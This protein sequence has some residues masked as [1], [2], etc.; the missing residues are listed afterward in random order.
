MESNT[1]CPRLTAWIILSGSAVHVKGFGSAL[2]SMTKRLIAACKSKTD[3]KMPRFK[4]RFGEEALDGVEPG[5][6]CGRE[7]EGPAGMPGQPLAHLRMLVGC[8]VVDDGVDLLSRRHLRLDSVEE[9]DELLVPVALHIA[10]DDGAV[11]DVEGR[12]QCRRAMTLVV[13]GHRPGAALLHWQAGLGAVERLDLALFIDREDDGMGGRINIETDDVAQLVDEP[14]VGGEFELFHPVRLQAVRA[15]D[16]LDGTRA[17]AD[18]LR[19]HGGGPVGRLGGW[20]GLGERHDAFGDA[21]PQRRDA[22]GACL[23]VQEAVVTCLHEAFLPAPHTGL[24]LAGPAHDLIGANTVR[25]QQDDLSPPDMLVWG[26]AVPRQRLQTAAVGRP[27]SDGNSGSHA[28][29]SHAFRSRGI[30]S[31]IQMLDAVH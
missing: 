22:R 5:C 25:A 16:A 17:D 7:V 3:R 23:I 15:P 27:K 28:P 21:R 26:V 13:V 24:R 4:R 1:W 9:A 8:V 14:R 2:C 10:A 11:E 30:P 31:R 19:H 6:R 18:D 12:E 20:G 29:D